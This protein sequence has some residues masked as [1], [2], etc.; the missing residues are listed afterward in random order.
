MENVEPSVREFSKEHH[1]EE[2]RKTAQ[3]IKEKRGEYFN[4]KESFTQCLDQLATSAQ[5]KR[6]QADEVLEKVKI[7]EHELEENGRSRIRKLSSYFRRKKLQEE[8]SAKKNITEEILQDFQEVKGIIQE[9]N[10]QLQNR[11]ELEK[12]KEILVSFYK[13]VRYVSINSITLLI[14]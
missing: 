5:E 13:G 3:Q 8:I 4:R 2:R 7:L 1:P 6:L 11:P 14:T 9:L 12:A 10:E